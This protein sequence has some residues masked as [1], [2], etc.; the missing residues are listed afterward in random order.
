ALAFIV[1]SPS[2]AA[3][4]PPLLSAIL[5]T[6]PG[7]RVMDLRAAA[8]SA[9]PSS[10]PL[11]DVGSSSCPCCFSSVENRPDPDAGILVKAAAAPM[12]LECMTLFVC[13]LSS[14]QPP[15][16]S[17]VQGCRGASCCCCC[18]RCCCSLGFPFCM[19]G[20]L[21]GGHSNETGK[22]AAGCLPM[23]APLRAAFSAACWEAAAAG[24]S[25]THSCENL[26]A[27]MKH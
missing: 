14:L 19:P 1:S 16:E 25:T 3:A 18:C 5:G 11:G 10:P 23:I 4:S 20:C 15:L 26:H 8:T 17:D 2:S 7:G 22:P 6:V 9:A 21:Q 12:K 27:L 24:R 13:R